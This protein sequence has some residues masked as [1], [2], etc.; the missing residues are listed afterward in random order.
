MLSR[1]DK[2]TLELMCK[3]FLDGAVDPSSIEATLK[4]FAVTRGVPYDEVVKVLN[5]ER[6][7]FATKPRL[8]PAEAGAQKTD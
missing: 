1:A 8:P 6:A 5:R 4:T 7:A 2:K 3:E